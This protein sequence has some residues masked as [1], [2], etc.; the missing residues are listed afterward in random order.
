MPHRR[1]SLEPEKV[2]YWALL[3]LLVW[4]PV[5]LGSNRGWAWAVMEVAAFALLAWW[6]V[7]WAMGQGDDRGPASQGVAGVRGAGGVGRCTRP[8]TIVPMP[9]DWVA[10]LSPESARIW[11]LTEILGIKHRWI[12]ISIEPHATMVS[13]VKTLAYVAIFFLFLA[14]VNNRQRVLTAARVLVYAAVLHA[15]YAVLMHLS[16]VS[17]EH[18]GTLIMHGGVG[19]RVLRQPQPL[20]GDAGDDARDRDRAAHRGAV[21]AGGGDVEGI[22]SGT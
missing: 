5:P 17:D 20:R 6:L 18:F 12:T 9:A 4:L 1:R 8:S 21:G 2:L 22:S 19:E 16:N 13:L 14:V 7:L 3:A 11:S 10:Y 15:V